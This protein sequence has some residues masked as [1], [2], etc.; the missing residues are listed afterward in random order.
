[1]YQHYRLM[2]ALAVMV[3]GEELQQ[4]PLVERKQC[5]QHHESPCPLAL[6]ESQAASRRRC[7]LR[8]QAIPG[9]S[10]AHTSAAGSP[11]E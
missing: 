2:T 8:Q 11:A 6:S 3:A 7:T 4:S 10:K 9:D 1:M 5:P